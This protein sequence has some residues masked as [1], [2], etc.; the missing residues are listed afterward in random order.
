MAETLAVFCVEDCSHVWAKRHSSPVLQRLGLSTPLQREQ[1]LHLCLAGPFQPVTV[2][3]VV[4]G[5]GDDKSFAA[6]LKEID[7]PPRPIPCAPRRRK[8]FGKTM[9]P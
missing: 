7:V 6:E 1:L 4:G 3:A 8:R 2:R 9:A 5:W